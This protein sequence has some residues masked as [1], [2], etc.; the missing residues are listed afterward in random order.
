MTRFRYV[1]ASPLALWKPPELGSLTASLTGSL[2]WL[3][4]QVKILDAHVDDEGDCFD[5]TYC[6]RATFILMAFLCLASSVA[7]FYLAWRRNK[8]LEEES[9]I[10]AVATI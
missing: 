7:A 8:A 5:D 10:K 1:S 4:L 2:S 3:A 6:F 9:P